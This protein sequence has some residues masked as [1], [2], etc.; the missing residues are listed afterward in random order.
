MVRDLVRTGGEMDAEDVPTLRPPLRYCRS[1]RVS[2]G[3]LRDAGRRG[4]E[5]GNKSTQDSIQEEKAK[6]RVLISLFDRK[7]FTASIL[8]ERGAEIY[9]SLYYV[10]ISFQAG[11]SSVIILTETN[12]IF[13]LIKTHLD[14]ILDGVAQQY[15]PL[16]DSAEKTGRITRQED[17]QLKLTLTPTNHNNAVQQMILVRN[18]ID[19]ITVKLKAAVM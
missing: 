17:D 12:N 18:H 14:K 1:A 13:T 19:P 5:D 10:R 11:N 16:R 9:K 6:A 7:A 3:G 2:G 4:V 8:S 15:P